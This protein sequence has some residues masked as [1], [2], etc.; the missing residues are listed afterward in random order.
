[1]FQ[2]CLTKIFKMK[3]DN[4]EIRRQLMHILLGLAIVTLIY[5]KIFNIITLPLVIIAGFLISHYSRTAEIPVINWFLK[6]FERKRHLKA[7]PGRGVLFYFIGTLAV[8]PFPRDIALASVMILAFGDSVSHLFGVHFGKITHPLSDKKFIEGG[9]VGF[10]AGLVGA[11]FF[12]NP[13]EAAIGAFAA[14]VAEAIEVKIGRRQV[15]DNLIVPL[16]A[17]LT[18]WLVRFFKLSVLL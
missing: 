14:M 2:T 4:L 12:I 15:D 16:V 9:I 6:K 10:F 7:F 13:G 3:P 5:Y 17:A 11:M 1:M 18:I 8:M